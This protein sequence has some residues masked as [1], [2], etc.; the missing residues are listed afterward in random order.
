[1]TDHIKRRFPVAYLR[2]LLKRDTE[3]NSGGLFKYPN[4]FGHVVQHGCVRRPTGTTAPAS[5]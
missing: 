1:M 4:I 3:S 5:S 2:V